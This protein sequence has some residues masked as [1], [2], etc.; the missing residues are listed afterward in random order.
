MY[1]SLTIFSKTID[2][3]NNLNEIQSSFNFKVQ[4]TF[5]IHLGM[6]TFPFMHLD[7]VNI[8]SILIQLYLQ[9]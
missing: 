2:S 3:S 7:L 4:L 5:F 8:Y 1:S 9:L 6:P